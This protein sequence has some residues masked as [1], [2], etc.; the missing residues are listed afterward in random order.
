MLSYKSIPSDP[1][2]LAMTK[3]ESLAMPSRTVKY[4]KVNKDNVTS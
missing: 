4:R 3:N 1:S 2:I